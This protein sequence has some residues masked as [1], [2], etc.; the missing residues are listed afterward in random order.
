MSPSF[1]HISPLNILISILYLQ[2]YKPVVLVTWV[3]EF[4]K[5]PCFL[6]GYR[7]FDYHTSI[8]QAICK[9]KD[10]SLLLPLWPDFIF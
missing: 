8:V 1:P 10:V 2:Y 9:P 5:K 6:H 7:H 4:L 3:A